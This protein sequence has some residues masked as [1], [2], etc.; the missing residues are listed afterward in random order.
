MSAKPADT[1]GTR[2][3][4][5]F[6]GPAVSLET[7]GLRS[8][9]QAFSAISTIVADP[10]VETDVSE[11][12]LHLV[13]VERGS[14]KYRVS[15]ALAHDHVGERLRKFGN[16]V[17]HKTEDESAIDVIYPLERLSRVA[18]RNKCFIEIIGPSPSRS[19]LARIGP[20][21]YKQFVRSA[22]VSGET[23]V[24]AKVERVGGRTKLHCAVRMPKQ[25]EQV[26]CSVESERIA[27]MLGDYIFESVMLRGRATWHRRSGRI[28]S[29]LIKDVD[30]PKTGSLVDSLKGAYDAGGSAWA[31][32]NDPIGKLAEIRGE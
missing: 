9:A 16:I 12:S 23:S 27:K 30:P 13:G 5:R 22:F 26:W 1:P 11:Q 31:L 3:L 29:M 21:T 10:T 28:R 14:A 15:T 7:V 24:F 19:V 2:F 32:L 6:T 4:V 17:N 20:N 8:L 18:K 25:D